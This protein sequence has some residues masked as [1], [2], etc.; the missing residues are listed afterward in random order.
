MTENVPTASTADPV[1]VSVWPC[2]LARSA[3]PRIAAGRRCAGA[4]RAPSTTT[5]ARRPATATAVAAV[6]L[7]AAPVFA[8]EMPLT[9]IG[10]RLCAKGTLHAHGKSIP[11]NLVIDFGTRV[12]LLV[13]ERT[14]KM[15]KATPDDRWE[16]RAGDV[17]LGNL[18]GVSYQL[19]DLEALTRDYATEL[20]EVPAVA[21][22]GLP[23]FA[24]FCPRLDVGE[25]RLRLLPPGA[26]DAGPAERGDGGASATDPDADATGPTAT[27]A[28]TTHST[29]TAPAAPGHP[30][31]EPRTCVLPYEELAYGYWL[32]GRGPEDMTLRVRFSTAQFDTII[33]STTADLAGA[34]GGDLASLYV[35]PINI[36]RYVALRPEDLSSAPD[37]RHDVVLG[38]NL[39]SCFRVTIDPQ[40]RRMRFERMR[41]PH[42]PTEDRAYYVARTAGDANAIEAF[43]REHT[44]SHLAPEAAARLLALRLEDDPPDADRLAQAIRFVAATNRV[45]RRAAAMVMMADEWLG[46]MRSDRLALA[47][48]AL[49]IGLES[50]AQDLNGVAGHQ[51]HARLGYIAMQRGDLAQARRDLLSAAFGL[52][53]D[54]LVNLW[55]GELYERMDKP[56]RAW[57]R[58]AQAAISDDPPPEAI[59]GL[60]RLHHDPA[61]RAVFSM[62]DAEQLLE[63]RINE[64]HAPDRFDDGSDAASRPA[65]GEPATRPHAR[66]VELFTCADDANTGGPE[67]AVG[68][69]AEYF[70]VDRV[71]VVE[72]HVPAP[73]AD[74]L[75][76]AYGSAR[77]ALY[78][79]KAAP[80][81]IVDGTRR[82][83]TGGDAGKTELLY[84]AY[85]AACLSPESDGD[86]GGAWSLDG[87]A[88]ATGPQI[89][90]TVRV[91]GPPAT[92]SAT[93]SA[94]AE[95][96]VRLHAV[97]CERIVMLPAGNGV[98]LR[99][100]VVR[101]ALTPNDG[102]ALA[103]GTTERTLD[104][105]ADTHDVTTAL[106]K[107]I[108]ALEERLDVHFRMRPTYIDPAGCMIVVFV[109]DAATK[110]VLASRVLD[111][112]AK[113]AGEANATSQ[114][115]PDKA[116]T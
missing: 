27:T 47:T 49:K 67:L 75:G 32:V 108:T 94:P 37:P 9:L 89:R 82:S 80:V 76:C 39:L 83:T 54:P 35:G 19:T 59:A 92:R 58:Y 69:I 26:I 43:V 78:G 12:P 106:D 86:E 73:A 8:Q 91:A 29:T 1:N 28:P 93:A 30:A 65:N 20:G 99:R 77:A 87:A 23:A 79:V 100:Y 16:F 114:P 24:A 45:E 85:K 38:T 115:A 97:L 53:R 5:V 113:P 109:Q 74:P 101:G 112:S 57:S 15:L 72:Y 68:A 6:L 70:G 40:G 102:V 25:G 90:A 56:V 107:G 31:A 88:V 10:G 41:E 63:G 96:D 42:F 18:P 55:M 34:P 103:K 44:T 3:A 116:G 111:V 14:Y 84:A 7:A 52:P 17:V 62:T 13:H 22:L 61:F 50:A 2:D 48:T 51:I 66:L 110:R 33:D 36:A 104:L 21:V 105:S 64:F 46:G 81:V 98:V 4:A 95:S 71:A 11:A 60:D